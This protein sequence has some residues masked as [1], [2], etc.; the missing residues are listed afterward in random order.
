MFAECG[1]GEYGVCFGQ[2][3]GMTIYSI[4]GKYTGGEVPEGMVVREVEGGEYAIFECVGPMPD[5]IQEVTTRI[6]KE[7]LPN[8]PD[9]VL[10]RDMTIEWYENGDVR[11]PN[12]RS[13]IWLPIKRK[14]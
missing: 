5:A 13:A 7:W 3:N 8:N 6:F 11:S 4:A 10:A 2:K 1:V 14:H 12:Y 9:Y